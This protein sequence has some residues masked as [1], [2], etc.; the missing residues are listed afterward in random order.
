MNLEKNVHCKGHHSSNQRTV[1]YTSSGQVYIVKKLAWEHMLKKYDMEDKGCEECLGRTI[2]LNNQIKVSVVNACSQRSKSCEEKK[3]APRKNEA[4][5]TAFLHTSRK[6]EFSTV[7]DKSLKNVAERASTHNAFGLQNVSVN[8]QAERHSPS[9]KIHHPLRI[10]DIS[11]PRRKSLTGTNSTGNVS[12]NQQAERHSPSRKTH[13]P[14][15]ISNISPPRRKSLTRV[16]ST[17]RTSQQKGKQSLGTIRISSGSAFYTSVVAEQKATSKRHLSEPS[18]AENIRLQ[19]ST[20]FFEMRN[21]I[22]AV[23]FIYCALV[24]CIYVLLDTKFYMGVSK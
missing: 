11:P 18:H 15:Q 5:S 8:Q 1:D 10:S 7:F 4:Q 3:T 13:H 14:V 22:N 23:L 12:V 21:V 6:A 19:A 20:I 9:Q 16:N 24:F 2:S 17:G